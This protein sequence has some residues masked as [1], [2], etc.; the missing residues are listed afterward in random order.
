MKASRSGGLAECSNPLGQANAAFGCDDVSPTPA[1]PASWLLATV[2]VVVAATSALLPSEA[3]GAGPAAEHPRLIIANDTCPDVTWGY[4][5]AQTRQ[6]F[7]DLI[8][9]HLDEMTRTDAGP[10]ESRNHYNVMAFVEI[11]AFLEKYPGRTEELVRRAR[12]GRVC[13]GPFLCNTLWGFQSAEGV[14]RAFYPASRFAREHGLPLEVAHHTEL[15]SLPW[16]MA[17]LLA[18]CG[19]RWTSV[20]FLDYDCTFKGLKN[21][22]LF[23]LEGP[24]GSEVRVILDAWASR[25]ANYTQGGWLLQDT[26]RIV[27]AWLPHYA[28]LGSAWPLAVTYASGTHSDIQ[29]NSGRQAR[30]FAE[31]IAAYNASGT[32]PVTLVN[33]TVAQ[34]C[35]EV[36]AAEVA[37]PFLPKL[38]GCFGHAWELWPVSLANIVAALRQN[39]RDFLAAES[40]VALAS[41]QEPAL[42]ARTR[43]QRVR[44]EWCWA[45]LGDHAWNGTDLQ[46]K[47]HNAA[48]RRGWTEQLARTSRALQQESWQAM[49]FEP[50]ADYLTVFN[51]LG[52]TN[53]VLVTVEPPAAAT[54]V[55]GVA[56]SLRIEH[57]RRQLS[58]VAPRVPPFGFREFRFET[59]HPTLTMAPPLAAS[60]NT[61]ESPFYRLR[62]DLQSGGLASLVHQASG[63]E[64]LV[65]GSGRSLC[66]TVFLDGQ[67]HTLSDIRCQSRLDAC[68]GELRVAGRIGDL[69]V[70]NLITLYVALDRVDFDV[71][72]EKPPTTNEQRLLHFFPVST[73][74]RDLRIETT[75]AVLR[76]APQPDGDLLPGADPR[77]FAVQ[78]FVDYSPADRMG[79]TIAPLDAY[80]LRLDQGALA[81]EALGNDQNGKEVT[82]DQDGERH[83]RFRY[84]LRAHPAG[85]DNAAALAWSRSVAAPLVVVAGRLPASWLDRA[86]LAVD[87]AFALVTCFKPADDA[88]PGRMMVRIWK[89]AASS[90]PVALHAPGFRRATAADLLEREGVGLPY[91]DGQTSHTVS[92]LGFAGVLL[93]R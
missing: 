52:F 54:G 53:D 22:P 12:E 27:D 88:G 68:T 59:G 26:K 58:F 36:D 10:P 69:R 74:T 89:T 25:Q 6:A 44:A 31:A 20:P 92:A 42:A 91:R 87:P 78:G 38:R 50:N 39:E 17:T 4:T 8:A 64:L 70:T 63:Q 14:L 86:H 72:I 71:R 90:G 84:S 41:R 56:S 83:F 45:M 7:A 21:P 19:F 75:A 11:Q 66:Q 43:T 82:P 29:P 5:E 73:G 33:G 67:E 93:E 51:P 3:A 46:N 15:P 32:N 9:A 55:Y 18:G 35:R 60:S 37:S 34:F 57:D 48:L 40:L 30:A 81:F 61:L 24:D 85:Y 13:L 23:R 62:V 28:G 2:A 1:N 76:P 47:R 16:G 79:V 80:A 77:R 65:R 49:G